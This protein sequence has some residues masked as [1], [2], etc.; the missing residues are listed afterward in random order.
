MGL[1]FVLVCVVAAAATH[2]PFSLYEPYYRQE[3]EEEEERG[4]REEEQER[5]EGRRGNEKEERS[6][7]RAA[8]EGEEQAEYVSLWGEV[9][10]TNANHPL[11]FV[12]F[13]AL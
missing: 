7:G 10:E 3:E 8:A 6:R 4:E 13:W 9:I 1:L 5:G 12:G 11:V 2:N